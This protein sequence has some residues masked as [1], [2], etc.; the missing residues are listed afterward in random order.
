MGELALAKEPELVDGGRF[1]S[2]YALRDLDRAREEV[3]VADG[4]LSRLR[5]YLD[6]SDSWI[7]WATYHKKTLG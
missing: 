5:L 6:K 7:F 3:L 1:S 4:V 2:D